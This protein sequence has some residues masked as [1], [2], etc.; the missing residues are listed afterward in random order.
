MRRSYLFIASILLI[1]VSVT[2]PVL[3]VDTITKRSDGKK[4]SGTIAAMT[5]T[6]LTIKRNQSTESIP[7]N[8]IAGIEWEQG[9]ADY[10]L[11]LAEENGGKID[12]AASRFQKARNETQTTNTMLKGEYDY[13]VARILAKQ[14]LLNPEKRDLAI[15]KLEA[16]QKAYSEHIRYFESLLQLIQLQVAANDMSAVQSTAELLK[17]SPWKNDQLIAQI[18]EARVLLSQGQTD[19]AIA[20]LEAAGGGAAAE[21]VEIRRR[22]EALLGQAR[23]L[24]AQA[25]FDAAVAILEPL[26]DEQGA[27]E[28]ESVLAEA[29]VLEGQALRG[30][31]K[32]KEAALAYLHVD[33]LFPRESAFHA[34]ALFQLVSLW[35]L[36]Q[37]PDRSTEAANKLAQLYPNSEWRKKLV[38]AE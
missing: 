19:R 5:R 28:S 15:Q 26:T 22:K 21:P 37:H 17:K 9:S 13:A 8:D 35:K 25:R 32:N 33:V 18:S 29:Y 6:E 10:K 12:N 4:V 3:A 38:A 16:V 24:I 23:G 7:A 2:G 36:I 20:G 11:A 1:S 30:L 31:G 34:E 14:A 27:I